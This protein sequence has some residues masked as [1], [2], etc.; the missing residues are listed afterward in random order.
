MYQLQ[1]LTVTM[2]Q[3]MHQILITNN[4]QFA[5]AILIVDR[6]IKPQIYVLDLEWQYQT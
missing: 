3:I 2:K 5:W 1:D 6:M 4:Q